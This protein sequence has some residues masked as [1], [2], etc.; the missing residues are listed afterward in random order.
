MVNPLNTI[1]LSQWE[2]TP[3]HLMDCCCSTKRLRKVAGRQT[4][5]DFAG[6][7]TPIPAAYSADMPYEHI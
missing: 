5:P 6:V 4:V 1:L 7:M 2:T 3:L